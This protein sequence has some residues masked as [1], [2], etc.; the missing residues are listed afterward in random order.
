MRNVASRAASSWSGFGRAFAINFLWINLSET[1]RYLVVI[2]PALQDL[3]SPSAGIA[4]M[5]LPIL[6][7]WMVWDTVLI[8]AA[9]GFYWLWVQRFGRN[10]RSIMQA[11][12]AFTLTVFG[13]VWLGVVNMGFVPPRFLILA[14]PLAFAEQ[15]VAAWIVAR[16]AFKNPSAPA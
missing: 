16:W 7:S 13:L 2:R 11:S 1:W 10:W 6:A 3:F 12:G 14:L 4:E 9:T 8:M 5:S 15:M